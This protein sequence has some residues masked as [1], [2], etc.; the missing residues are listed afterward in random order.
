MH[1]A[2]GAYWNNQTDGHWNW[3]FEGGDQRGMDVV[4]T[5]IWVS[6]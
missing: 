5:V 6:T 4:V 1:S 3:K 2:V